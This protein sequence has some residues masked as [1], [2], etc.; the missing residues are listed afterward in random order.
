MPD[1]AIVPTVPTSPLDIEAPEPNSVFLNR[2]INPRNEAITNESWAKRDHPLSRSEL[3]R[4]RQQI[5]SLKRQ[6]QTQGYYKLRQ[7]Y[8]SITTRLLGNRLELKAAQKQYKEQPSAELKTR[9]E[10]L[11]ILVRTQHIQARRLH[12][13]IKELLPTAR[14]YRALTE[15]LE[16]HHNAIEQSRLH[17]ALRKEMAKE[18]QIFAQL[19]VECWSGLGFK[20]EVISGKKRKV[21]KVRFSEAHVTPDQIFYKIETST[22]TMTGFRSAL[23]QGVRVLDLIDPERTLPELTNRCQRQVQS[24]ATQNNGAWIIINRIG[25]RDGLLE[26]VTLQQVLNKYDR[27]HHASLPLPIGVGFGRTILWIQVAN[28]PHF[29]IGG[30]T[31]GGKSNI[32]NVLISTLAQKHSPAQVRFLLIDLKEGLEF[33]TWEQLPHLLTA[34]IT[35]VQE[36]AKVLAQLESL[37]KERAKQ[38]AD[39]WARTLDEYNARV[40]VDKQMPRII[41]I[42]DEFAAIATHKESE[43]TIQDFILQLLNKGRAT[44][45]HIVLCT[46]NPSV[47]IIPGPSKANMSFRLAG[48]MPT[49]PASMTI[50]GTG[51]AAELPDVRGRMIAMVGARIWQIQTPHAREEDIQR[52]LEIANE[53]PGVDKILLPEPSG[54][55]GFNEAALIELAIEE[56]AGKLS[57]RSI[58]ETIKDGENISYNGLRGMVKA[59]VA[60]GEITHGGKPYRFKKDRSGYV[61]IAI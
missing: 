9:C 16:S 4:L 8:E 35:D 48:P 12:A 45:I 38:F 13:Q 30:S 33:R 34:P 31:G 52:A 2:V 58:Y 46:Q 57:A 28:Y 24:K 51:D 43:K 36:A 29:L 5:K 17:T 47:D 59:L 19:L 56:F 1:T 50:L 37:R 42:F 18:V 7:A 55:V 20:Y 25:T 53:W 41:V 49:K 44:G 40:P 3:K 23:P 15:R 39:V 32:E 6:L 10:E 27:Y 61:L 26:Y 60:K 14:Q 22:K 21:Q 54:V 11:T